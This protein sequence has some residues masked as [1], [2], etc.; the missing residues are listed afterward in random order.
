MR[1]Y[2]KRGDAI[3]RLKTFG[4]Y[5]VAFAFVVVCGFAAWWAWCTFIDGRIDRRIDARAAK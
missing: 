4:L 3:E 1:L 2:D 5:A